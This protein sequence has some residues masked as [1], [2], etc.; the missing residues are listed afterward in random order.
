MDTMF[1]CDECVVRDVGLMAV[2][3]QSLDFRLIACKQIPKIELLS[4]VHYVSVKQGCP[5]YSFNSDTMSQTD[6]DKI[7]DA[8]NKGGKKE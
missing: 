1:D 7:M 2:D 5:L 4:T 8:W 6:I 3:R